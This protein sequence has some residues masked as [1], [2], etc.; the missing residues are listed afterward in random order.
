[1]FPKGYVGNIVSFRLQTQN[2]CAGIGS[3]TNPAHARPR[4]NK[5]RV[6]V[7]HSFSDLSTI[8]TTSTVNLPHPR[9]FGDADGDSFYPCSPLDVLCQVLM[10]LILFQSSTSSEAQVTTAPI[11]TCFTLQLTLLARF[12]TSG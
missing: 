8:S 2:A 3:D 7:L 11:Q 4:S 12:W 6:Y 10:L 9:N 1:M 5:T